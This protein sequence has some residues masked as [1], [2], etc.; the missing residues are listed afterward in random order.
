MS[1]LLYYDLTVASMFCDSK[2]YIDNDGQEFVNR[3]HILSYWTKITA[4]S[5]FP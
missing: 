1:V 2:E 3:S 5:A 4:S